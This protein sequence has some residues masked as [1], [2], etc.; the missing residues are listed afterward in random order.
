MYDVG[1]SLSSTHPYTFRCSLRWRLD[2]KCGKRNSSHISIIQWNRSKCGFSNWIFIH[3]V[4]GFSINIHLQGCEFIRT[5]PAHFSKFQRHCNEQS[6]EM[7]SS[8]YRCWFSRFSCWDNQMKNCPILMSRINCVCWRNRMSIICVTFHFLYR[9][10]D[11]FQSMWVI[12]S[13]DQIL[14]VK[15][16]GTRPPAGL[17]LLCSPSVQ[18]KVNAQSCGGFPLWWD[19]SSINCWALTLTALSSHSIRMWQGVMAKCHLS[20]LLHTVDLN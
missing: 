5:R 1:T 17:S 18:R 6:Y 13:S 10:T 8:L 2:P 14:R 20:S 16:P 4:F 11:G 3:C 9:H 15:R 19:G 7:R 12:S